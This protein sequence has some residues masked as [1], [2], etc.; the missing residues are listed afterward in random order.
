MEQTVFLLIREYSYPAIFCLLMLGIVGLPIPD[1]TLIA[2]S[3]FLVFKN[4]LH[5]APALL[6]VFLGSICGIT[7]SY[8]LGRTFGPALIHRFGP[9]IHIT[10]ERLNRA[11]AWLEHRGAWS[12]TF[13]YF[14]PGIRHLTA[15]V[16]GTS[17]L[18][19]GVFSLFAYS[20][21]FLWSASFLA[22]GYLLGD[23]WSRASR[24]LRSYG[25]LATLALAAVVL[26]YFGARKLRQ[27]ER[28]G[29]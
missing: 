21:G 18:S 13:G 25:W 14:L 6:T 29:A 26:I 8:M 10:E 2:F 23:E 22:V 9:T 4:Q 5:L 24:D 28:A 27:R 19:P 16:A 1:E 11:R 7:L 15:Y 3:G 20:G 12:L 17:K